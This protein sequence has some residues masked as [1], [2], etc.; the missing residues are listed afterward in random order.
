[1]TATAAPTAVLP[2]LTAAQARELRAIYASQGYQPPGTGSGAE[3]HVLLSARLIVRTAPL[4]YQVTAAG[5]AWLEG[6]P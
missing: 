3:R 4:T 6:N 5:W 1:M 2:R